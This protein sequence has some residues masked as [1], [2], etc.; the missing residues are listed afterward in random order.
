MNIRA[1]GKTDIGVVRENNEDNFLIMNLETDAEGNVINPTS[2]KNGILLLVADG[3]GGAVA[4]E[5]ASLI[6]VT[7]AS[8]Y[9]KSHK[10]IKPDDAVRECLLVAHDQCHKMIKLN[11]G[12]MGMGTVATVAIVSENKLYISQI[13][14]TRLYLYRNK[15]LLQITEDQNFVSEL[16]RIGIIT[17]EQAMIHPQR[18]AVTQA[19]GSIEPILPV[20]YSENLEVGDKILL[21]SDG[22]NSMISDMEIQ[23]ILESSKKLDVIIDNLIYA[24]KDSGGHDNITVIL[25]EVGE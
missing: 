12:L 9:L 21:C 11:P 7:E 1:F 8:K 4:G 14:D 19:V 17:P 20:N 24:A 5:T 13:G 2:T 16:V 18:N 6:M 10:K 25:A 3:M 15:T 23:L 22:L